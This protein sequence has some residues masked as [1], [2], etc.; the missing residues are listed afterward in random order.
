MLCARLTPCIHTHV[1]AF[2]C[3]LLLIQSCDCREQL[4]LALRYVQENGGCVIYLQ[5]EGRGIGLANK[6]AAYSLQDNGLDTVEANI[7]LGFP[8][9]AREYDVIPG[10]LSDLKVGSVQLITNNPRKVDH[11]RKHG[12]N[13]AGTIPLLVPALNDHNRKYMETK[14]TR[15]NHQNLE[16][17][18]GNGKAG[19][20]VNGF[21]SPP[22][23]FQTEQYLNNGTDMTSSA[24]KVSHVE[25][26][27]EEEQA[28]VQ[29]SDDGWCFGRH[30]VVAAIE[31]TKRGEMVVVVDDMNRENEGDLIMS[32]EKCMPEDMA[33]I[34][35]YSSGVI[36]VAL[37]DERMEQLDIPPM[38]INNQDP[39]GTAFGVS[40]DATA[41]HG[42]TTG[43]SS[44]DRSMTVQLLADPST[45]ADDFFRPG[46]IF[47]LRARP[48]GVLSRDGHTEA[49]VD[50][51]RLAG[52]APAGVLCEIVSE[53]NPTDMMRLPEMKRFC[54][55][56]GF[57]LTSIVDLAQFRR[58]TGQ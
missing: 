5:Q 19:S 22:T 1:I 32:A 26:T 57:V 29:A 54:Q 44:S 38:V 41:K 46:H 3:F 52:L 11:L 12:V 48:G 8:E 18:I 36:C 30:S 50:L 55:E 17:L 42:C 20:G 34:I 53:D 39:K 45:T 9:D 25:N 27:R 58:E 10:I 2:C 14:H 28:G 16:D 40:I 49:A 47:P 13:V 7:H 31:A 51:S 21:Q 15:M 33:K 6:I 24:V 43:I 4:N 37:E 23:F 56:H 35:R